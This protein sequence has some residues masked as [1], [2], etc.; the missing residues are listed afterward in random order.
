MAKAPRLALSGSA[1]TGKTALGLR[2]AA[3]LQVPFIP[4][5]MRPRIEAGLDLHTLSRAVLRS[6]VEEL[7][8]E[9]GTAMREAESSHGGFVADRAP[10]DFLAFWLYYGFADD[11]PATVAFAERVAADMARLDALVVLPWGVL[12]LADDGV[13]SPNPWRQLHFQALLE[14]LARSRVAAA[15]LHWL[16]NEVTALDDRVGWVVGEIVNGRDR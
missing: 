13:R 11:Q 15:R 5:G 12:P 8:A 3:R 7:Y 9:A 2:L 10:L 16:P 4:E 6:L 14:G 1:G